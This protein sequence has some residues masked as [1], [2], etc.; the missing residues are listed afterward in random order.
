[1][2]ELKKVCSSCKNAFPPSELVECPACSGVLVSAS[3]NLD[4]EHPVTA[5]VLSE[6]S[7]APVHKNEPKEPVVLPKPGKRVSTTKA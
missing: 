5:Q 3:T 1:M 7:E 4:H 2:V 6:D